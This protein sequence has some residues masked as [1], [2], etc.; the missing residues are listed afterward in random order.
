M[1]YHVFKGNPYEGPITW[2]TAAEGEDACEA[3]STAG[4]Q[5][6]KFGDGSFLP[7]DTERA[8]WAVPV[9]AWEA[10]FALSQ[11]DAQASTIRLTLA[12]LTHDEAR[13]ME[14]KRILAMGVRGQRMAPHHG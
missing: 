2:I 4:H 13:E 12:D 8:L 3:I 6:A 1:R 10:V 5:E 14:E 7:E 9:D 11:Y